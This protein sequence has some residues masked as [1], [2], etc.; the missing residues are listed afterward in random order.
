MY[1][2]STLFIQYFY[3]YRLMDIYFTLWVIILNSV[4]KLFHPGSL[5]ALLVGFC[6]P[7]TY[8]PNPD[9]RFLQGFFFYLFLT[10]CPFRLTLYISYPICRISYFSG[11]S[12][13][14][15]TQ[16]STRNYNFGTRC[17]SCYQAVIAFRYFQLTDEGVMYMYTNLHISTY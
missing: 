16:N 6:I 2:Y 13:F 1:I 15:L 7:L 3:Q 11:K 4:D 5:I 14:F 17:A 9:S 12:G 8:L 10:F